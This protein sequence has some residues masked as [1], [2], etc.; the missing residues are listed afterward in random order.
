MKFQ[1]WQFSAGSRDVIQLRIEGTADVFLV[2]GQGLRAF[3]SG[4]SFTYYG[5]C[6][7]S[8]AVRLSP[9]RRDTWY[10]VLCPGQS[11]VRFSEPVLI[12]G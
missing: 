3:Q 6:Y 8:G 2:D 1:Y 5:G 4:D 7:R 12:A 9:P 11:S 10:L